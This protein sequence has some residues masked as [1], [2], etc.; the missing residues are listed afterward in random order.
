MKVD[1][2]VV[3]D[4]SDIRRLISEIL[5]DE[6]FSV[7][8]ASN[9][10]QT[11]KTIHSSCPPQLVLLDVWLNDSQYDG[12]QL[13]EMILERFPNIPVIMIS[14]HSTIE[15][16]V[17]ALKK[18][19]V[20]FIEKPFKVDQLLVS[21]KRSIENYRLKQEN[22]SLKSRMIT[23]DEI[24]GKSQISERLKLLVSKVAPTNSRVLVAGGHGVG[25]EV[26][27]RAIHKQSRRSSGAFI[28]YNC[29]QPSGTRAEENLLGSEIDGFRHP[30]L[31]EKSHKG[32]LFLDEI[33]ALDIHVQKRLANILQEQKFSPLHSTRKIQFDTRI[34]A[35]SAFDLKKL[36]EKGKFL[37]D[38][39]VR[40][41][42]ISIRVPFLRER[43]EEIIPM[44]NFFMN[45]LCQIHCK[46]TLLLSKNAIS[47]L[48]NY[49]WPG[50]VRQLK[51]IVEWL[52]IM[53]TSNKPTSGMISLKNLP[54]E[55]SGSSPIQ[56][57]GLQDNDI[58]SL[59][60]RDAREQFEK[61]YLSS[62]INRFSGNISQ[63][64]HFVGMERS[65]LHRKL[66]TLHIN[67]DTKR[68]P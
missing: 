18:G 43:R 58:L 34:I 19:A 56:V 7:T 37:N 49:H 40:I 51:N 36:V 6:G 20:D 9:A 21:V 29:D 27:A 39:L 28:S 33:S 54:P 55:I 67:D 46:K 32:T 48:E 63:T 41:N 1:I 53:D 15:T 35:S 30:G 31:I 59:P 38:L 26:V 10:E 66:K 4:E 45:S 16:A 13:L 50:N 60:L 62:Q 24:F 42:L 5:T 61:H 8:Q 44:F 3:D 47:A 23:Q 68:T 2:L 52:I 57:N 17:A 14:G 65:A 12:I 11:I 22:E 25:K 64:A